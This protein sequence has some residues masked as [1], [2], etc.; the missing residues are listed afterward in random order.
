MTEDT[1][2]PPRARTVP[3]EAVRRLHRGVQASKQDSDDVVELLEELDG[4][5]D[6]GAGFYRGYAAALEDTADQLDK[7]LQAAREHHDD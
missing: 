3:Y 7:I 5:P 6:E 1:E 4:V 2:T